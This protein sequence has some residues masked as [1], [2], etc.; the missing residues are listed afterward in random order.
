[1]IQTQNAQAPAQVGRCQAPVDRLAN[2]L[3]TING[4]RGR[5]TGATW[6]EERYESLGQPMC[7]FDVTLL[8]DDG[9]Q[10]RVGGTWD[11]EETQI[12][13]LRYPDAS[14][15]IELLNSRADEIEDDWDEQNML[16]TTWSESQ[17]G[18]EWLH[19]LHYWLAGTDFN[20][21]TSV[22]FPYKAAL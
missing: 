12:L 7:R 18:T 19:Q 15:A 16:F 4:E 17:I 6:T 10:V 21:R 20:C 8:R 1:M 3:S 22:S 14:A 11:L 5:I 13:A 2:A 9:Q